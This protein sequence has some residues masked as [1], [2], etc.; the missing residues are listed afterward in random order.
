MKNIILFLCFP[1]FVNA[2]TP[3]GTYQHSFPK[4]LGWNVP[5][6]KHHPANTSH[7]M[8]APSIQM[9]GL[10]V[11][12]P[13]T[14][15][16]LREQKERQ[17]HTNNYNR[18]QSK[19]RPTP[20]QLE[21]ELGLD[22]ENSLY[23]VAPPI[24]YELPSYE[25][26]PKTEYFHQAYN[27]IVAM[28]ENRKPLS[29]KKAVFLVENA[30]HGNRLKYENF[31]GHIDD[32]LTIIETAIE[33]EGFDWKNETAKKWMLFQYM[34]DTIILKDN[35]G[36]PTFTHYPYTYDF[37]DPWAHKDKKKYMVSK[38]MAAKNGQCHSLPLLYLILA[39]ELEINAW[40][41]FA[42]QHS[43][44]RIKDDKNRWTNVELTNRNYVNDSWVLSSGYVKA[45]AIQNGIYM[46][47]LS[48]KELIA[49]CLNDLSGYYESRFGIDEFVLQC[50]D[51]SLEYFPNNLYGWMWKASYQT[52]LFQY[53]A[54]QLNYPPPAELENYPKLFE[55]GQQMY[56]LYD[57]IDQLGHEGMPQKVYEHWLQ[58]AS[59]Q[60]KKYPPRV[61]RP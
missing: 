44:I 58:T 41:A 23:S 60:A 30:W 25:G 15:T 13:P 2:Q 43:Y 27:E 39:E 46:D 11:P 37:E 36:N 1:L 32:A 24:S 10:Q 8:K 31:K 42:P 19:P 9:K 7:N 40:L 59:E 22:K 18:V 38:L 4:I 12:V 3:M 45:D 53:V 28:L 21:R 52:A 20:E 16:T 14:L 61:I 29:L 35:N 5:Y 26:L 50:A 6:P 17:M 48:K 57:K 49:F 55:M 54:Q 56:R 47:T 33:Q 34:A 51:K